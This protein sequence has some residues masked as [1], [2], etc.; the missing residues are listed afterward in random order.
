M[1]RTNAYNKAQAWQKLDMAR[2]RYCK[3][4]TQPEQVM[5]RTAKN[6]LSTT[7]TIQDK[8][9]AWQELDKLRIVEKITKHNTS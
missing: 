2:I 9:Q 8:N 6:I 1:Q 5:A 4:Y 3:N 7:G